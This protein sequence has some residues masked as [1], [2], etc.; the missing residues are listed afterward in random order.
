M[1][2]LDLDRRDES[3]MEEAEDDPRESAIDGG[4]R[5]CDAPPRATSG[6]S[7]LQNLT[8]AELLPMKMMIFWMKFEVTWLV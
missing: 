2:V 5:H 7:Y 3:A 8:D 1:V 6:A 4:G